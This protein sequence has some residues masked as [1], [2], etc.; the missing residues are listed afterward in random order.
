M[1][2]LEKGSPDND[3][4]PFCLTIRPSFRGRKMLVKS[5]ELTVFRAPG[6]AIV[7]C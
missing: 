1:N 2:T 4:Q 7:A 5:C 6:L 3:R